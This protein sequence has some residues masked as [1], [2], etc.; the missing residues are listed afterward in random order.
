MATG[1]D[2]ELTWNPAGNTLKLQGMGFPV[3]ASDG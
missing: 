2:R 1:A 3:T